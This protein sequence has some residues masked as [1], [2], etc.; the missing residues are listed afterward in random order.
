MNYVI[1][2]T[3]GDPFVTAGI[4]KVNAEY[5]TNGIIN[6]RYNGVIG[7]AYLYH[8]FYPNKVIC[9]V[10]RHD[11]IYEIRPNPGTSEVQLPGETCGLTGL[12]AGRFTENPKG[13]R[14][15]SVSSISIFSKVKSL[16]SINISRN[17]LL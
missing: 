12:V 6:F 9:Q 14:F 16:E 11:D 3:S 7:N 17:L 2:T 10:N 8:Q 1:T 4:S 13:T 5:L 15:G